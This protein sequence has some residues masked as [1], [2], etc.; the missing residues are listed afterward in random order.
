MLVKQIELDHLFSKEFFEKNHS[1]EEIL[2]SLED[3]NKFE[4]FLIS[5]K[6]KAIKRFFGGLMDN[7][8]K[9]SKENLQQ[10]QDSI[11]EKLE[12]FKKTS[13]EYDGKNSVKTYYDFYGQGVSA[14]ATIVNQPIPQKVRQDLIKDLILNL[15]TTNAD[16]LTHIAIVYH[17]VLNEVSKIENTLPSPQDDLAVFLKNDKGRELKK[18]F[19]EIVDDLI[20]WSNDNL[21][22]GEKDNVVVPLTNFKNIYT[23]YEGGSEVLNPHYLIMYRQGT[24]ALIHIAHL[25]Q[26]QSIPLATRRS[27][28]QNMTAHPNITACADGA[29]SH[30]DSAC[31]KLLACKSLPA[32]LR[33][34]R[35]TKAEQFVIEL[36]NDITKLKQDQ[37]WKIPEGWEIHYVRYVL[38]KFADQLGIEVVEDEY[39]NECNDS[40]GNDL[41]EAFQK[42]ISKII[43]AE[44]VI[45]Q[46]IKD[47]DLETLRKLLHKGYKLS[48]L[49][50]FEGKLDF[51][52]VE[53]ED[54]HYWDVNNTIHTNSDCSKY[55]LSWKASYI[56][57]LSLFN[58]LGN[59]GYFDLKKISANQINKEIQVHYFPDR[60]L[61]IAYLPTD[62]PNHYRPFIPYCIE[63][64]SSGEK[65]HRD[66][67]I[68]F[69]LSENITYQQVFEITEAIT[70]YLKSDEYTSQD[71]A[72]QENQL[73][74]L[75]D[76][77]LGMM[78][79]DK[80]EK[81]PMTWASLP[82]KVTQKLLDKLSITPINSNLVDHDENTLLALAVE[83]EH[84]PFITAVMKGNMKKTIQS[85]LNSKKAGV[86]KSDKNGA[87]PLLRAAAKGHAEVVQLLLAKGVSVNKPNKN[88]DTPLLAAAANGHAEIVRLL[89]AKEGDVNKALFSMASALD[90]FKLFELAEKL[91]EIIP[92]IAKVMTMQDDGWTTLHLI[93]RYTPNCFPKFFELAK[94]SPDIRTAITKA[95]TIKASMYSTALHMMAE[96]AP[97]S[98]PKLFELAEESEESSDIKK[99]IA[100]AI[101]IQNNKGWTALHSMVKFAPDCLPKLF[102]LAEKSPDI[103][104]AIA[105]AMTMQDDFGWT[106]F[107]LMARNDTAGLSIFEL[108]E[109]SPE[110][111][112]A[113]AKAMTM[114]KGYTALHMVITKARASLPKL[115]ELAEKLPKIA[116]AIAKTMTRRDHYRAT[117][118][119]AMA[120]CTPDYLPKFFELAKKSPDIRKAIAEA[121]K[122]QNNKRQTV[123]HSIAK[124]APDCLPKLFELAEKSSDIRQAIAKAMTILNKMSKE[125]PENSQL[126]ALKHV[127]NLQLFQYISRNAAFAK[128]N[129]ALLRAS[130]QEAL[131]EIY[132]ND[133]H[134]ENLKKYIFG[135][136]QSQKDLNNNP[137]LELI[138]NYVNFLDDQKLSNV[139]N[140]FNNYQSQVEAA[141]QIDIQNNKENLI[142]NGNAISDCEVVTE[143]LTES[144]NENDQANIAKWKSRNENKTVKQELGK[145]NETPASFFCPTPE[146]RQDCLESEQKVEQ[147]NLKIVNPQK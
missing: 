110:I 10:D 54:E 72:D 117:V 37:G 90:R 68:E 135:L 143:Q 11:I 128:E 79:S 147:T 82:E 46:I 23:K 29:Y 96:Y 16:V 118:L 137:V 42:D 59:G 71:H 93:A 121:M 80:W 15:N 81:Y 132:G 60:T 48:D 6:G 32:A 55:S 131:Q 87:T 108:A 140:V 139:L 4:E 134:L 83:Y 104:K 26:G 51:Y 73:N 88:C 97:A 33:E 24:L 2:P 38:N 3:K 25:M 84:T 120:K 126:Q 74:N 50:E 21:Q 36:I 92:A 78:Q 66:A 44:T 19:A 95:M 122:M 47:L 30:I 27:V 49:N 31:N 35:A 75:C 103:K 142:Y 89:L 105:E 17:H 18:F 62:L 113:I 14:L 20:Q 94:K 52:G 69:L 98:L 119:H 107:Y 45:E 67:L 57:F 91:P 64:F 111:T 112:Q 86:N 76:A 141:A 1:I 109:K 138:Q 70:Q 129:Q 34:I 115:F 146:V 136:L 125:Q 12:N 116:T 102:G 43:S 106:V 28:I 53:A 127:C 123:L 39:A 58:R 22:E 145:I 40:K 61:K 9:W 56:I 100:E 5:K 8:I 85:F 13:I 7:L 99:A 41:I 124:Y 130:S 63:M 114:Q 65:N 144:G 77:M 101:K 133:D